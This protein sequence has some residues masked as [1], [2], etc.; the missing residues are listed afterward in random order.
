[1]QETDK[2][3]MNGE[4]VDWH[5][6]KVH[7]GVH[8]LHYGTGVFEGIRCYE[9]PKGPAVFRLVDHLQ[10]LHD[11][12]RLLYMEIPYTVEELREATHELVRANGLPACYLRPIAFFGYG[13]LGVAHAREPG[14]DRAHELAVG[15]LPGRGRAH[16]GDHGEGLV[17]EACRPERDPARL[18]GDGDLPQ[19]DAGDDGGAA[20]RATTRGSC[21]PTTATSP[22]GRGRTSSWSRTGAS[23]TPPLST[24]ILP[25]ITRDSVIQIAQDLGYVVEETSIIRADLALADEVFMTGTAAEVTPVRAVDDIEIGVG[26]VTL[27]IQQHYLDTVNG[28]SERWSHWLD[29][30]EGM[31]RAFRPRPPPRTRLGVAPGRRPIGRFR[32]GRRAEADRPVRAVARRAGGGARHRG[33]ALGPAVARPD[34][35]PLRGGVRRGGRARRTR[36]RSPAAPQGCTCSASRPGVQPGDEVITSPYSFVASANCAIYEGAT[37]VFA[38]IDARTLNL[39][40]AAVE[41]AIT[42]AHASGRRCRHLRLSERAGRTASDLRAPRDRPDRR[43]L[44]GARRRLQGA[45]GRRAGPGRGLRVLPEQADH[46]RRGRHRRRPGRRRPGACSRASATRAG[47]TAAA[48]STTRGSASTTGSTTSAPRSAWVSSR[49]WSRSSRIATRWRCG[50]TSSCRASTVSASRAP[51]TRITGGPGSSTWSRSPRAPTARR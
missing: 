15:R 14:G 37:P 13:S 10:R 35:R 19:L 18:E 40:P 22:T 3:W 38:D 26:P 33:A 5:E 27:E 47:P 25:G 7:V 34:D 23:C 46:D 39:D 21:S 29:V 24:S 20:R 17:L 51:T 9:T 11:S 12:A 49:S 50:T 30:V 4:L 43:R 41:A 8:G 1:M 28:R 36:R 48:G 16:E 45:A 6:A 44:R 32:H 31:P 42:T 2:I